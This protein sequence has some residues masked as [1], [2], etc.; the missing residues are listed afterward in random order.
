MPTKTG[1]RM[2]RSHVNAV[3]MFG[4]ISD[5]RT[6]PILRPRWRASRPPSAQE[7]VQL[8]VDPLRQR[9]GDSGHSRKVFDARRLHPLESAEV[10]EQ[11][12]PPLRADAADLL[13]RRRVARLGAPRAMP[14]DREAM[15]LVAD[16]LQK[17][18]PR[19]VR[20]E[21]QNRL[22]SGKHDVLESGFALRALGNADQRRLMQSLLGEH[23]G[24]DAHL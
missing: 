7:S 13:Q 1:I 24:G 10:R 9:T 5:R 21:M 2:I 8:R 15:R 14:L 23:V 16:L 17:M 20:R 4:S 12:L 22:A 19:M 6:T 11:R 3:G 18:Q